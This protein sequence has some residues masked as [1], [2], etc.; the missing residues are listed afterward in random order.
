MMKAI[1]TDCWKFEQSMMV[2]SQVEA[3]SL[4]F[5]QICCRMYNITVQDYVKDLA[6]DLL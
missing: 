4:S 2:R 6:V 1:A 3:D 5:A